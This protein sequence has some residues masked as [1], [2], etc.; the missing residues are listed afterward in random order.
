MSRENSGYINVDELIPQVSLEKAA[1]F[2]G[3]A[4]PD[5]HR[6]GEEIRMRCFLACGKSSDTGDRALAIKADHPATQWKCHSYGCGKGG[7]LVSLC[8]LMKAGQNAGGRPRGERFKEI[9]RDLKAMAGG[10]AG[11]PA[12]RS[13]VPSPIPAA[14]PAPRK[15]NV[16]LS[17]SDNERAR[18]LLSLDVKFV[19]DPAAMP[20]AAASYVRRRPFLLSEAC[21]KWRVGY[22]PRDTGGA[23]KSGGTMRGKIVYAYL[24]ETGDVL[25][26]FGRDPE[27]EEKQHRWITGGKLDREPEKFHFVKGFHRGLELF[28]QHASRLKEPGYREAIAATGIVVVEGPNDVIALD[29][30]GVPAVGLCSNTVTAEQC[31]KIG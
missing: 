11:I 17:Q 10:A 21:H 18:G 8:D 5:L 26:W 28:G 3:I 7:N 30:L 6:T 22:L 27:F 20:P 24:S 25:T 15:I 23:D 2:Y 19:T 14:A 12:P 1:A 31:Q 4:L 29:A 13:A 9:A 16:P